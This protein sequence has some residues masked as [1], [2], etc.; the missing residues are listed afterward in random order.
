MRRL[1]VEME[2]ILL[3]PEELGEAAKRESEVIV[4]L[5]WYI[6]IYGCIRYLGTDREWEAGGAPD[7]EETHGR[8][9]H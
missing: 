2:R 4:R 1:R 8:G 5:L 9:V 6:G 3:A 7:D